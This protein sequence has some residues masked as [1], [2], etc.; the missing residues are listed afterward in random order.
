MD[1]RIV[2]FPLQELGID[3][4]AVAAGLTQA[5]RRDHRHY[6]LMAVLQSTRQVVFVLEVDPQQKDWE[7]VI[8]RLPGTQPAELLGQV[9]ARRQ[10]G[11]HTRGQINLADG[12]TL[13]VFEKEAPA[14]TD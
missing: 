1:Y 4:T 3:H 6:R 7:Y 11:F 14:P 13:G 10:G 12:V 8:D 9:E 2:E 5:V